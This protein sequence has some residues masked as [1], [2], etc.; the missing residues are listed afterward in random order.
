MAV[1]ERV[2][3][4]WIRDPTGLARAT[5][6]RAPTWD[7]SGRRESLRPGAG[8]ETRSPASYNAGCRTNTAE[9]VSVEPIPG[10]L[11]WSARVQRKESC[12]SASTAW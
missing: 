5:V 12:S 4:A 3:S 10:G 7:I 6:S 8:S 9:P 11:S 2:P 1:T